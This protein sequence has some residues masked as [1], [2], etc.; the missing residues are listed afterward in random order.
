MLAAIQA[1]SLLPAIFVQAQFATST[2][3]LW[4]GI[5]NI[6]FNGETWTGVGTF[7]GVSV[8]EEGA[9]VEAKGIA[10][11]LSGIDP[12]ALADVLQEVQ[13]GLPV[14]VY[15][16][17]FS[18]GSLISTPLISW[19]GRMDQPTID[20]N[21]TGASL[22]IACENRLLEMNFP[23]DRRLTQDDLNL[24]TPGDLGCSFVNSIQDLSIYWGLPTSGTNI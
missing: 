21:G 11:T 18:S 20:V 24:L 7:G 10:I 12:T 22:S 17:L 2:L 16:G 15:L 14:V 3:Y 8:I 6:S 23:A 5:G 9:T 13:L 1:S 4:S 19:A